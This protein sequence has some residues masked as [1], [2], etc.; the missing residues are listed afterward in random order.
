MTD[1]PRPTPADLQTWRREAQETT[2]NVDNY[3]SRQIRSDRRIL[4]LLDALTA[5]E[6]EHEFLKRDYQ[7]ACGT[8]AA[9][10][11]AA[12]GRKG[13]APIRGV[14]ED[15]ADVRAALTAKDEALAAA[16]VGRL[17]QPVPTMGPSPALLDK[18]RTE[19]DGMLADLFLPTFS[20]RERAIATHAARAS[21]R[22]ARMTSGQRWS[23]FDTK[24]E[25]ARLTAQ[26][27]AWHQAMDELY[28]A[29]WIGVVDLSDPGKAVRLLLEKALDVERDEL[30]AQVE[31]LQ[32]ERDDDR[33][34]FADAYEAAAGRE[35]GLQAQVTRLTE[36]AFAHSAQVA[37]EYGVPA[38]Y[39]VLLD[40]ITGGAALAPA[41]PLVYERCVCGHPGDTPTC[42]IDH[43]QIQHEQAT[44][45]EGPTPTGESK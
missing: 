31:A 39:R 44:P 29:N 26:V 30:K 22:F 35:V 18:E 28:V 40:Y 11:E 4:A 32:R 1:T 15:C 10:H 43:D 5:A 33:R 41:T 19:L 17:D 20:P 34:A 24:A 38:G 36:G 6:Q 42:P 2:G 25:S 3:F 9:M 23:D 7:N 12:T 37:M 13:E 16:N 45:P 14:V 21:F 27:E 8:I